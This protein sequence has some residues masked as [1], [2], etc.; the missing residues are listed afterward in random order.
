[1]LDGTP[2]P[3]DSD[4]VLLGKRPI[5]GV[6]VELENPPG[7]SVS[8]R[9]RKDDTMKSYPPQSEHAP[10]GGANIRYLRMPEVLAR[11][12]VSWITLFRWEKEGQFP[13]RRKLGKRVVGW[14]EA[15]IDEWCAE[16]PAT[17][18]S[19]EEER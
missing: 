13:R 9:F 5:D 7:A 1:M 6:M 3:S 10:M 8:Y 2:I 4:R 18:S 16:R 11:V 14:I 15:E 12:G 19:V 17:S